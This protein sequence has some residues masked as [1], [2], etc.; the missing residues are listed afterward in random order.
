MKV[1]KTE[2]NCNLASVLVLCILGFLCFAW[3]ASAETKTATHSSKISLGRDGNGTPQTRNFAGPGDIPANAVISKVRVEINGQRISAD[4]GASATG[5]YL[6]VKVNNATQTFAFGKEQATAICKDYSAVSGLSSSFDVQVTGYGEMFYL[7]PLLGG[8]GLSAQS[9]TNILSLKIIVT[10][11]AWYTVTWKSGDVVLETDLNLPSLTIPSYDGAIPTR[12][13]DAQYTYHSFIG[14]EPAVAPVEKDTAYQAVYDK[15]VNGYTVTWNNEYT[16]LETDLDVPYGDFPEYNGSTPV[17]EATDQYFYTFNGWEPTVSKVT[18]TTAYQVVF[19]QENQIYTITFDSAGG[20][21]VSPMTQGYGTSISKPADPTREGNLFKGWNPA[22]PETMPAGNLTCT[23]Q[24]QARQYEIS[25]NSAGGSPVAPILVDYDASI[26]LPDPPTRTGY[27]FDDWAPELPERM[28]NQILTLSAMWLRNMYSVQYLPGSQ[29]TFP[30]YFQY[31][32]FN[33]AIPAIDIEIT[34]NPGYVFDGWEPE[35]PTRMPGNNIVHT[36]RWIEEGNLG[37]TPGTSR[38]TITFDSAGGTFVEAVNADAGTPL[39]KPEPPV[40]DGYLFVGWAPEVPSVIPDT[41]L[42]CVAQWEPEIS[43]YRD[44]TLCSQGLRLRDL[45]PERTDKWQMFTPL[46]L[47][48][49]GVQI[50]PL[51][52]S[53]MF[54]AG[55]AQVIIDEGHVTINYSVL[56]GVDVNSEFLAILPNLDAAVT[57]EPEGLLEYQQAFGQPISIASELGGDTKVLLY[58]MNVVDYH[59]DA[60]GLRLFTDRNPQYQEAVDAFQKILD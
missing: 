33:T 40:R 56:S 9:F 60:G 55:E 52:A 8:G 11:N 32:Y 7:A 35:L 58:I 6:N 2:N 19:T 25:F 30:A 42:I 53:N 50:I 16:M 36:A 59:S 15:T 43:Y 20:D 17:K 44:N 14:W 34:G 4:G 1:N 21:A 27:T 46:D 54:Y 26:T 23:A 5:T 39:T 57:T 28:P 22:V 31:L 12:E 51:I 29:G 37:S 18:G 24:W 48:N 13:A 49:D 45:A 3:T 38:Y 41:D 10:Y 47:S